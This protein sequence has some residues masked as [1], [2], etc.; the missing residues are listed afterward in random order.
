M[1]WQCLWAHKWGE[2]FNIR[3]H[4]VDAV[5]CEFLPFFVYLTMTA[6]LYDRKCERCGKIQTFE[7]KNY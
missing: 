1:N 6:R 3:L 5:L 7:K 2:P 4:P